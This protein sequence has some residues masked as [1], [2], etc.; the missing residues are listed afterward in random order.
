M[1]GQYRLAFTD[2]PNLGQG[3]LKM[4]N[5]KTAP[6]NKTA[7]PAKLAVATPSALN[8]EGNAFEKLASNLYHGCVHPD[9]VEAFE[10]DKARDDGKDTALKTL[11][12][13]MER[14]FKNYFTDLKL[15]LETPHAELVEKIDA[16]R[17]AS[18]QN[19]A[20]TLNYI[21]NTLNPKPKKPSTG[22]Q[23]KPKASPFE[24]A[25]TMADT[26]AKFI[27]KNKFNA[28]E[29]KIIMDKLA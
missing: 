4:K 20:L 14:R 26:L 2:C 6:A 18:K 9:I 13:R 23:D 1:S 28:D 12:N 7:S 29:I 10:A 21:Q 19:R 22:K 16:R 24:T 5:T 25:V 11:L 17:A 15:G 27:K 3:N 8:N